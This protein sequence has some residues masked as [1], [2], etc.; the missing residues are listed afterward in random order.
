MTTTASDPTIP[1]L[2]RLLADAR[3]LHQHSDDPVVEG[4]SDFLM[5]YVHDMLRLKDPFNTIEHL[6]DY[7]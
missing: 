3:A 5:A 6:A 2:Q 4:R 1:I 7:Q